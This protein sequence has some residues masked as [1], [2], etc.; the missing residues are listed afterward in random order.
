MV[1]GLEPLADSHFTLNYVSVDVRDGKLPVAEQS[2]QRDTVPSRPDEVW[3][4][5]TIGPTKT[6]SVQ[7]CRYITSF[8]CGYTGYVLSY[9]HASPSQVADIQERWYADIAQDLHGKPRVFRCDNTSVNVSRHATSFHVAK[10]I[11]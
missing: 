8:T 1:T 4:M 7:G 10:A 5:D 9:G 3:H 6:T 2:S 11:K